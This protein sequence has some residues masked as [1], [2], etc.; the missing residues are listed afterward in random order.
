[1]GNYPPSA[2]GLYDISG[3]VWEWC[4]DWFQGDYYRRSPRDNPR[5][6]AQGLEKV[7]RGG[8]WLCDR[9]PLLVVRS[10]GL[11]RARETFMI[12]DLSTGS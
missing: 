2:Y 3:N 12:G 7:L 10:Q 8:S 1:M 9:S 5:G 11:A 6:P 4:E